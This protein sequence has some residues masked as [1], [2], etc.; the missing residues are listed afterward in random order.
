MNAAP[1]EQ[2]NRDWERK[3]KGK[4]FSEGEVSTASDEVRCYSS[5]YSDSCKP[6]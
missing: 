4:K 2:A 5:C 3:L 6:C 1:S